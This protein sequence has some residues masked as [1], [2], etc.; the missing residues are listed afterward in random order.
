MLRRS[1]SKGGR[2]KLHKVEQ[3]QRTKAVRI[4]VEA[5]FYELENIVRLLRKQAG[6]NITR[7]LGELIEAALDKI[8]E[9]S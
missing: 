1:K 9:P 4:T 5:S 6:P 3:L 2:V 8:D 7:D